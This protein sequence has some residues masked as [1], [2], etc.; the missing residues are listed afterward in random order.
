MTEILL[1][2]P[3]D[4]IANASKVAASQ[5]KSL[6]E[7]LEDYLRQVGRESEEALSSEVAS[8]IGVA[9]GKKDESDYGSYLTEKYA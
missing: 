5:G 3:S 2:I 7:L 1:N 9:A 6:P 4:I 8:L